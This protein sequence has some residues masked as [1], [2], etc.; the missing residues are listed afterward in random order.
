M[1]K[2]GAKTMRQKSATK[3]SAQQLLAYRSIGILADAAACIDCLHISVVIVVPTLTAYILRQLLSLKTKL[4]IFSVLQT[5]Y[6]KFFAY[7]AIT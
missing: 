4:R 2:S 5:T 6:A 3:K 7:I 1:R